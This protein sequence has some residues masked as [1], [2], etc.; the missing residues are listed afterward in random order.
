MKRYRQ[1][2]GERPTMGSLQGEAA[3]HGGFDLAAL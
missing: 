1:I 2:L 3:Y